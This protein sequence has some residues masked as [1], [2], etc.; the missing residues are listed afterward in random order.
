M[1]IGIVSSPLSAP[2]G[3]KEH[4]LALA[5]FLRRHGHEVR[6][7][8]PPGGE[9]RRS[10]SHDEV[11]IGRSLP[12]PA[13]ASWGFLGFSLKP[14]EVRSLL[15][16]ER[17][18]LIHYHGGGLLE[19]QILEHSK[20][21]NILTL[22]ANPEGSLLLSNFPFLLE[23]AKKWAK[24][25]VHGLIAVSKV[26]AQLWPDFAGPFRIIPNGVD[27]SRFHPKVP[28]IRKF[29]DGKLNILFVGR[30]DKRKGLSFLIEAFAKIK[31]R[32]PQTRL[33]VV[34]EGAEGRHCREL[35]KERK[36]DDV[37][38]LGF[39]PGE[40]LPSYYATA[41]IFCSP[42]THAE[43]FGI[44]LLEAMATGKP[45]AAFANSGYRQILKGRGR[46]FLVPV[47][48]VEALSGALARLVENERLRRALGKWG[49]KEA[50]KYSWERVGERVW[51]F[52]Q[53]VLARP[54]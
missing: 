42:A 26:A 18:D 35:V 6:I 3:V 29:L 10:H 32:C 54:R 52:Y 50:E 22:H 44:V 16:R 27:L 1:K 51:R 45:V 5:S 40:L 30:F 34:G 28:K 39:V 12:L 37:K 46:E 47:E 31:T 49:M 53:E 9:R 24:G 8:A 2:G 36:L 43:S 4:A 23:M 33:L 7:I 48:D 41:D 13:N 17:F 14:G 15:S 38:F 11:I 19:Y 25:K 20:A 21:V